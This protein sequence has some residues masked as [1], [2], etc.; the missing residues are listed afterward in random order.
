MMSMMA[1]VD[2][3]LEN[4]VVLEGERNFIGGIFG[5]RKIFKD[6]FLLGREIKASF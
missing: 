5:W 3:I 2:S 1:I 6:L 4:Y